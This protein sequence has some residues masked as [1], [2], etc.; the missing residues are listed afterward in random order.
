MAGITLITRIK[1]VIALGAIFILLLSISDV[2]F[3]V[4]VIDN[5][6]LHSHIFQ[7]IFLVSLWFIAPYIASFL[8][9]Y[10][11]VDLEKSITGLGV[12]IV[13]AGLLIIGVVLFS[14]QYFH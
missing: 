12:I 9:K 3:D 13:I 11:L 14:I 2:F 5:L 10:R 6:F 8:S 1:I 4:T 7:L